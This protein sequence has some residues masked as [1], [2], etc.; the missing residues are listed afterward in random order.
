MPQPV[1]NRQSQC[2]DRDRQQQN[3]HG[4]E[5]AKPLKFSGL[6]IPEI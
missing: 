4:V 3:L 2:I 1:S 6:S 5:G